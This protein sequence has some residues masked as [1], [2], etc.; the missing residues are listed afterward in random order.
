MYSEFLKI[1]LVL[2]LVL[3]TAPA[4]I[5]LAFDKN[6]SS[7]ETYSPGVLAIIR[8]NE[9]LLDK[10]LNHK[11]IKNLKLLVEKKSLNNFEKCSLY[12]ILGTAYLKL[13]DIL[14]SNK[15]FLNVLAFER[16]PLLL[17]IESLKRLSV[18]TLNNNQK[19]YVKIRI[20]EINSKQTNSELLIGLAKFFYDCMEFDQAIEILDAVASKNGNLTSA[21]I[22]K[23]NELLFLSYI[24]DS[25]LGQALQ[26]IELTVEREPNKKNFRRLAYIYAL[27]NDKA[28]H[29]NIWETMYDN[30]LLDSYETKY[31]YELL[32]KRGFYLKARQVFSYGVKN[33]Y[34]KLEDKKHGDLQNK[35]I[36]QFLLNKNS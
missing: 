34:F 12:F 26:L 1:N 20:R 13:N 7:I 30:F 17:H 11:V 9:K 27:I 18:Q 5:T 14:N 31:F 19:E 21:Q 2:A 6:N 35:L 4:E 25:D 22:N 3:I 10:N 33:D 15:M 36:D 32:L 24:G 8:E 16:I 28:N 23:L 29:L